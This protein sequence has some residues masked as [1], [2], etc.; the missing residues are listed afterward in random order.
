MLNYS[1]VVAL[2]LLVSTPVVAQTKVIVC[3]IEPPPR[4]NNNPFSQDNELRVRQGGLDL[5]PRDQLD[6]T[7]IALPHEP[8]ARPVRDANQI[9]LLVPLKWESRH[10]QVADREPNGALQFH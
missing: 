4:L 5:M 2:A 6:M 3:W 10:C 7:R 9:D 1:R 8:R